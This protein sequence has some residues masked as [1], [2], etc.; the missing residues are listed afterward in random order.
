MKKSNKRG[1]NNNLIISI[2]IIFIVCILGIYFIYQ[3]GKK[4]V[5]VKVINEIKDYNYVLEDNETSLYKNLFNQLKETLNKKDVDEELYATLI[6]K[7]F[8]ADF[9]N[10]NNKIS[11]NDIGGVQYIHPDIKDNFIANA[12][13]TLYKYIENN[14][15]GNRKQELPSIKTISS[16]EV[17]KIDYKYNNKEDKNAY[18]IDATWTYK[19]D[20]GY[21]NSATI[22]VVHDG[23]KLDIVELK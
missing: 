19:K 18:Q 8:I 23:N 13:D 16:S 2:L 17:T 12:K 22:T 9:Y 3:D 4:T 6:T 7:L 10:L 1:I 11:K 21:Q 5:Q 20:L 14:V 15:N